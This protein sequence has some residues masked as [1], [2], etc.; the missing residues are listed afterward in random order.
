MNNICNGVTVEAIG[1]KKAKLI[2][3][4]NQVQLTFVQSPAGKGK[5]RALSEA[6]NAMGDD[7]CVI[8]ILPTKALI[9]QYKIHNPDWFAIYSGSDVLST[10]QLCVESVISRTRRLI[11]TQQTIEQAARLI[12][13]DQVFTEALSDY[14]VFIDEVPKA[15]HSVNWMIKPGE[16]AIANIWLQYLQPVS[17]SEPN[18]FEATRADIL[19]DV[20]NSKLF[21]PE[22][23]KF[24][25][26]LV[27]GQQV[28]KQQTKAG[29]L[30]SALGDK[31]TFR[32]LG[33]CRSMMLLGAQV[34]K[35]TFVQR[36]KEL[37]G[38][39]LSVTEDKSLIRPVRQYPNP[40]R[41]KF[42]CL[43]EG[44][45]SFKRDAEHFDK[46]CQEALKAIPEGESFIYVTNE[47]KAQAAFKTIADRVFIPSGGVRAP[48]ETHGL[49]DFAG[50]A[51]HSGKLAMC[52]TD[53]TEKDKIYLTPEQYKN[54]F[55]HCVFLGMA[56]I[57]ADDARWLSDE[58][59]LATRLERGAEV[60][61]QALTRTS[62]RNWNDTTTNHTFV[63]ICEDYAEY[64]AE[65]YLKGCVI[66]DAAIAHKDKRAETRKT[67][68]RDF[69][70]IVRGLES[71]KL[72][73][74]PKNIL[75]RS[76]GSFTPDQVKRL[77]SAMRK[78]EL[79]IDQLLA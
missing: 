8:V 75:A 29:V 4:S 40:E 48:F 57:K 18:I 64:A 47:D 1:H 42:V 34:E 79:E 50:V 65:G 3:N 6:I 67:K 74:T 21:K 7:R 62:L 52:T 58:M 59:K 26:H 43:T 70:K 69:M 72:K 35:M 46:I 12:G 15:Q 5:T 38:K 54:G 27:S 32:L 17:I 71:D 14:D 73:V 45:A 23:E 31:A 77:L 44:N 30:Y 41:V 55:A 19:Q 11:V 39:Q 78:N 56:N 37:Y 68:E 60:C 28:V 16:E 49:N 36:A 2:N 9:A 51:V 10:T 20:L 13:V 22:R 24:L 61:F 53:P 63:V 25:F 76:G 66:G 33:V